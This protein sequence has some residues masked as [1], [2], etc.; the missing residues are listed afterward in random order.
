MHNLGSR[1]AIQKRMEQGIL[2]LGQAE[3]QSATAG[4]A[5]QRLLHAV[6]SLETFHSS[7]AALPLIKPVSEIDKDVR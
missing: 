5:L 4:W 7:K 3:R 1:R 2:V 6:T